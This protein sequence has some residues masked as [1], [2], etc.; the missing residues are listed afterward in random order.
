M[1]TAGWLYIRQLATGCRWLLFRTSLTDHSFLAF[2]PSCLPFCIRLLPRRLA[3]QPHTLLR[4][5]PS[6]VPRLPAPL[7]PTTVRQCSA[8]P[9]RETGLS[10]AITAAATGVATASTLGERNARCARA[11]AT[12]TTTRDS[13]R[14]HPHRLPETSLYHSLKHVRGTRAGRSGIPRYVYTLASAPIAHAAGQCLF[15]STSASLPGNTRW[16]HD[17]FAHPIFLSQ[18]GFATLIER[19]DCC[20]VSGVMLCSARAQ[21]SITCRRLYPFEHFAT[22]RRLAR[23]SLTVLDWPTAL[24]N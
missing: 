5:C 16:I 10:S 11:A 21:G 19:W 17:C 12:S 1:D 3:L 2:T 4:L 18:H 9:A 15:A 20:V 13:I 23:R 6:G 24:V 22:W 14:F 7:A 8:Q